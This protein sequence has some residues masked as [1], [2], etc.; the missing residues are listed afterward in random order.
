V[1]GAG[2]RVH[3]LVTKFRYIFSG[4]Q[5][6]ASSMEEIVSQQIVSAIDALQRARMQFTSAEASRHLST[7]LSFIQDIQF[8][9]MLLKPDSAH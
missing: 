9:V 6:G 2:L 7:A 1:C 4:F 8:N 5:L 3:L